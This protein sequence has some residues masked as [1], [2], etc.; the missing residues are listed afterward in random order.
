VPRLLPWFPANS[1][2]PCERRGIV[3][4]QAKRRR[5]IGELARQWLRLVRS[6]VSLPAR[7]GQEQQRKKGKA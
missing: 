3:E 1:A 6:L 4:V 2:W 7:Q 5:N